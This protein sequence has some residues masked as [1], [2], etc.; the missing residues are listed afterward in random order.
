MKDKNIVIRSNRTQ[1]LFEEYYKSEIGK[2]ISK[3]FNV[4]SSRL[5]KKDLSYRIINH[6][7][8]F[9]LLTVSRDSEKG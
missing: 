1:K 7:E 9:G 8:K 2:K 6:W 4:K 5:Q 3:Q